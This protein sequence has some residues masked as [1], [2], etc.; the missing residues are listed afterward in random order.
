[1]K[2]STHFK[3][4]GVK[5][6]RL[7]H[8]A[9]NARVES[10]SLPLAKLLLRDRSFIRCR[11]QIQGEGHC[12]SAKKNNGNSNGAHKDGRGACTVR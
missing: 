9:N 6:S 3:I 2:I 7:E 8:R 1:M 10:S 5:L 11:K 12:K 4:R